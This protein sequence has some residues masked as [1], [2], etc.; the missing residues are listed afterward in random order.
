MKPFTLEESQVQLYLESKALCLMESDT[1]LPVCLPL[2]PRTLFLLLRGDELSGPECMS[3]SW[4]T[5]ENVFSGCILMALSGMIYGMLEKD[6]SGFLVDP[7]KLARAAGAVIQTEFSCT[8]TRFHTMFTAT[9]CLSSLLH[10]I[11]PGKESLGQ[12]CEQYPRRASPCPAPLE[13][14]PL[15]AEPSE[16]HCPL[17]ILGYCINI[18][19]T[20]EKVVAV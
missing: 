11:C 20:I 7:E 2:L 15:L 17:K 4:A 16:S 3:S 5:S 1:W 6:C 13:Q 14:P 10:L 8:A 9:D 19:Q 18:W 12:G